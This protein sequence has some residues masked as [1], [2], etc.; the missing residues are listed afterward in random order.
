MVDL[1]TRSIY[2]LE[3][4]V[5]NAAGAECADL[6]G[7]APVAQP[8]PFDSSLLAHA[9]ATPRLAAELF[10]RKIQRSVEPQ[11]LRLLQCVARLAAPLQA[12]QLAPERIALTAAIPEVDAPSPCWEA[13]EAIQRQPDKLLGQLFAN[14]PPLHAITLLNSSVMAYVAEAL[15]CNGAM[16][17]YCSQGNAGL[18]ALIEAVVQIAEQR[19][20]AALVVSSSPNLTPALYLRDGPLADAPLYGEGAAALLLATAPTPGATQ[21]VRI[22][23]FA[24]AYCAD[25]ARSRLV[26]E[27][28]LNQAL[29]AQ[30]LCLNDL[31]LVV[32]D[33]QDAVLAELLGAVGPLRSSRGVTGELGASALLTEIAYALG[34]DRAPGQGYALLMTRSRAGHCGALLLAIE[35]REKQA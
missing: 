25:S 29:G 22:A 16:G 23:G 4:A 15:Q 7:P 6:Q 33:P 5:L 13:V 8:L 14:T 24:R 35:N 26:A 1:C 31:R 18:D 32:A 20:D 30:K 3:V 28:V 17:G 27:R 11:G 12:L 19:A 34:A 10:D 9:L 2:L 21:V